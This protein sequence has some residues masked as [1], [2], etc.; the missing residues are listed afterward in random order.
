M[1]GDRCEGQAEHLAKCR[2]K[3][4]EADVG[5]EQQGDE[6][7]E[8]QRH[9]DAG[10]EADQYTAERPE[11]DFLPA[12]AAAQYFSNFPNNLQYN[13]FFILRLFIQQ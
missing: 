1:E 4:C 6:N 12:R 8:R 10:I 11:G 2:T 3:Q 13:H 5:V 7:G 9:A